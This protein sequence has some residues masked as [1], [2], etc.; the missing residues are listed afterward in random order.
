MP[1]VTFSKYIIPQSYYFKKKVIKNKKII[2]YIISMD[3][4]YAEHKR[5]AKHCG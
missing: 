1:K 4:V 5:Y 2:I 3:S